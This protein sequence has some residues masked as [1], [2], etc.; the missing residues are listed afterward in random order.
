MISCHNDDQSENSSCDKTYFGE[1]CV[2]VHYNFV[3]H[4]HD[5]FLKNLISDIKEYLKSPVSF[6]FQGIRTMSISQGTACCSWRPL[7]TVNT[8]SMGVSLDSWNAYTQGHQTISCTTKFCEREFG[9]S[10]S[11]CASDLPKIKYFWSK[12]TCAN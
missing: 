12:Q 11:E 9:W 3:S 7:T 4:V 8:C 1:W 5:A 10:I 2:H 6:Y